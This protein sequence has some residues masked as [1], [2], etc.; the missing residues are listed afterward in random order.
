MKRLIITKKNGEV[1]NWGDF[2]DP[3]KAIEICKEKGVWGDDHSIEIKD[4]DKDPDYQLQQ[5]LLKRMNEYP[6]PGD[7][8]DAI[9]QNDQAAVQKYIDAC[10]AVKAKYPKPDIKPEI[11]S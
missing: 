4:L 1:L 7:Y 10:K 11:N 3:T 6:P 8:L 2:E 5:T 9:V